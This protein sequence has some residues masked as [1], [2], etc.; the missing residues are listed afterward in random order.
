M[1]VLSAETDSAE[2]KALLQTL[3]AE[4]EARADQVNAVRDDM[5]KYMTLRL[6]AL[7]QP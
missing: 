4:Y 1:R 7:R 2:I 5:P 6:A 3:A